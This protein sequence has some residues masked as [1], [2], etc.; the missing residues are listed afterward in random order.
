MGSRLKMALACFFS[1]TTLVPNSPNLG[2]GE[3]VS[4]LW[5]AEVSGGRCQ[6]L[7]RK[8]AC[9]LPER[10]DQGPAR[11]SCLADSGALVPPGV[12]RIVFP[13]Y[14]LRGLLTFT[15]EVFLSPFLIDFVTH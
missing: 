4:S 8:P 3:A 11:M 5:K 1:N 7:S 6:I 13:V 12:T 15:S 2:R 14:S 10:H 9:C